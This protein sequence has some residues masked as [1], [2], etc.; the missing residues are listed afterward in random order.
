MMTDVLDVSIRAG[1]APAETVYPAAPLMVI[2]FL[3]M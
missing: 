2:S 3:V 1:G